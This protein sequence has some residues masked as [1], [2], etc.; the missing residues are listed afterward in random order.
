MSEDKSYQERK[1]N[2][3]RCNWIQWKTFM[4]NAITK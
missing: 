1:A 3:N 2:E 4:L